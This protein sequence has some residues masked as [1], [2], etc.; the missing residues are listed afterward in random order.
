MEEEPL[1]G[2]NF[3]RFDSDSPEEDRAVAETMALSSIEG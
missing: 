1:D 3:V 2:L